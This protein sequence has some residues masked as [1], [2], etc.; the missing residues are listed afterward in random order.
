MEFKVGD[1][2][3]KPNGKH[4]FEILYIF[5]DRRKITRRRGDIVVRNLR[6]GREYATRS[7]QGWILSDPLIIKKCS[8][9]LKFSFYMG[10]KSIK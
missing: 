5:K 1:I 10:F 2:I 6:N 7:D 9:D 3:R 4:T 8:N